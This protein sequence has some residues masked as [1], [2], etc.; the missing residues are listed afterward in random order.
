MNDINRPLN[1]ALIGHKFMGKAHTHAYTDLSI[2]FPLKRGITKK[3]LCSIG[4]DVGETASRWG[5]EEW[6]TDWRN[7]VTRE[8]IDIVDIAAPSVLHKE[9]SIL[10]AKAGKHIFCE[11]PLA[12]TLDDAR[13]MVDVVKEAGVVNT[14]GF[15]Y[16]KV[17]AIV[18]AKQLIDEGALG[19]IYHFRG[20]YSQDWLVDPNFPLAWRL[21]KKDAG[22]GSSWDLG[23][24]VI[25]LAR[26][27]VGD[28][29]E[30]VGQQSTFIKERPVA[31]MEDGLLAIAGE[32]RGEVDV[33]DATS[34]LARFHNDAMGLFEVTRFGTGH[35]NLNQIEIY[36]SEGGLI[37]E[38]FENMNN[39]KFYSRRDPAHIQGYRII[40]VGEGVHPYVGNWF[41]AGHIIGFGE[42]FVHEM[43]DFIEAINDKKEASPSFEDGLKVQEILAAVDCS[44][45]RRSWI[46]ISDL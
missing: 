37:W 41:P 16:R 6:E 13:E 22:A 29:D 24:H 33:D 31:Q 44:V 45:E 9:I 43:L 42:T 26:Y 15:N 18:L 5:W 7:V 8:D 4:N 23:A 32:S 1:V 3:V 28:I 25:D 14:I 20:L 40:Q 21:R 17:P 36:G 2:F 38:G 10:A 34:F 39:L 27:L 11:K 19:K 30:V 35:R 46:K 12:M